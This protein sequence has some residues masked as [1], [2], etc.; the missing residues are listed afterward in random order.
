MPEEAFN[1][2]TISLCLN[3]YFSVNALL[4]IKCS[5]KSTCEN[6]LISFWVIIVI[7]ARIGHNVVVTYIC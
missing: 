1:V 2:S 7:G 4:L 5:V 3:I 6:Y